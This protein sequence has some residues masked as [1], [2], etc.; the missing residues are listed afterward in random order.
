[1]GACVCCAVL[2]WSS[3]A[4]DGPLLGGREEAKAHSLYFS[5]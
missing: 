2:L 5:Q 1:M 4:T 3:R